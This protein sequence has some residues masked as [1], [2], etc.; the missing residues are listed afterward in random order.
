MVEVNEVD[1]DEDDDESHSGWIDD[2]VGNGGLALS[3]LL[4]PSAKDGSRS[5]EA[6]RGGSGV[7]EWLP[8]E[9]ADV[10]ESAEAET[11]DG[12]EKGKAGGAESER[13]AGGRREPFEERV[14]DNDRSRLRGVSRT[15]L[16]WSVS[17]SL[18]S[19]SLPSVPRSRK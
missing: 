8:T 7:R 3:S 10:E 11:F 15:K 12:Q 9:K 5:A 1:S 6:E 14:L 19:P 18:A 16:M 2:V 13:V 4:P 17:F